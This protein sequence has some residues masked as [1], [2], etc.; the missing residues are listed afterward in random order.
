MHGT[1]QVGC[2]STACATTT[3]AGGS[4]AISR[5]SLAKHRSSTSPRPTSP[6]R[7]KSIVR[8]RIL[9]GPCGECWRTPP[10][11]RTAWTIV[12][13]HRTPPFLCQERGPPGFGGVGRTL[14]KPHDHRHRSPCWATFIQA[15]PSLVGT[16]SNPNRW[17]EDR[18]NLSALGSLASCTRPSI[19]AATPDS[20]SRRSTPSCSC[21]R[22][23]P[24]RVCLGRAKLGPPPRC[25]E[26]C[27]LHVLLGHGE[28]LGRLDQQLHEVALKRHRPHR[29][30]PT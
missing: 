19:G 12:P 13:V 18:I 29:A 28:E 24:K 22:R 20:T 30:R 1:S 7:R 17:R 23:P 4:N 26:A 3:N 2:A 8:Q 5:S 10:P 11:C 14:V 9:P 6:R 25:G 21:G 15:R 16:I 27:R